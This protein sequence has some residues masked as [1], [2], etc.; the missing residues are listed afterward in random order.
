MSRKRLIA[1]INLIGK[2]A[3]NSYKFTSYLP[4]GKPLVL[5]KYLQRW[6]VD[7]ISISQIDSSIKFTKDYIKFLKS[8]TSFCNI[9]ISYSGG[10]SSINIV[11]RVIDSGFD[12]LIFNRS[13]FVNEHL[14]DES[15]SSYGAQSTCVKINY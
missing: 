4:V 7:E 5:L 15:I 8:L 2:T 10:L 14:L 13:F 9:P 11:H 6:S 12:K 3:V 1:N